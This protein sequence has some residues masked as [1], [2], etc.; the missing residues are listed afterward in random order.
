MTRKRS[1]I[2]KCLPLTLC[3]MAF[4]GWP[5][6]Q[7]QSAATPLPVQLAHGIRVLDIRLAIISRRLIA[8]HGQYPQRTA[9]QSI[10]HDIHAFLTSPTSARETVVVSIKQ[11]DFETESPKAFSSL[12]REEI[13]AGPGGMDMWFL[14]NRIPTLGEVRGKAIM[15]SRFGG[16]G[17]AWEGGLEGLGIHPT[18]WPDSAEQGFSWTCKDVLVRT[19]DWCAAPVSFSSDITNI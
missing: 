10:L 1:T 4:Y 14:E 15:F 7:C 13:Q 18:R 17:A 11:E 16:D 19:Q 9:F 5:V 8:Y 3:S 6:S 12:V 2:S